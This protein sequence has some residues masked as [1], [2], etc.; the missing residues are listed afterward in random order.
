MNLEYVNGKTKA[1]DIGKLS[2]DKYFEGAKRIGHRTEIYERIDKFS[3]LAE[4][5]KK[6]SVRPVMLPVSAIEYSEAI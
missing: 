1:D 5:C 3:V 4:I 6:E 2:A